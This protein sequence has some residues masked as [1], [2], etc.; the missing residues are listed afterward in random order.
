MVSIY[1]RR[2]A[3]LFRMTQDCRPLPLKRINTHSQLNCFMNYVQILVTVAFSRHLLLHP[4]PLMRQWCYQLKQARTGFYARTPVQC[5]RC[6][7][8]RF[9]SSH[10]VPPVDIHSYNSGY[11]TFVTSFYLVSVY[12]QWMW[13]VRPMGT[14]SYV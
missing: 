4:K 7:R 14:Y 5:S 8:H 12:Y 6:K 10:C 2:L 11:H 9:S 3:G 1:Y 13:L